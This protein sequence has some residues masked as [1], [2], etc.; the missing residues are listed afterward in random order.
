[1]KK[2]LIYSSVTIGV[3]L[4]VVYLGA[5]FFLGS[6]VKSTVNRVGPRM[7]QTRVVLEGATISP[8]S[9]AGTLTGL[10]IYNPPGWADGKAIYV[11]R[12]HFSVVPSSLFKNHIIVNQI[13]IDQ[14]EFTYETKIVASNIGDLLKN[15]EEYSKSKKKDKTPE[16]VDGK[17]SRF[18]VKQFRL[19]NGKVIVGIGPT[20]LPMT[21]PPIELNDVGTGGEGI[22]GDQLSAA[23]MKNVTSGVIA[24]TAHAAGQ[25]VPTTGAAALETVKKT[26]ENLKKLFTP[27]K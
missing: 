24:A 2:F 1:M 14:A 5:T 7:T 18:E 10:S 12:I 9:G 17:P 19:T 26:G 21:M 4:L 15:I 25:I 13:E 16:P 11:G 22:T 20:A 23:L 8:I 6:I 3:L 27:S